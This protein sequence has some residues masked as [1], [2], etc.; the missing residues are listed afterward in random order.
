V[1]LQCK[2]KKMG[3]CRNVM[4]KW[5]QTYNR[6]F[7]T[8]RLGLAACFLAGYLLMKAIWTYFDF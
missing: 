6:V 4:E 7:T 1:A 5:V 8:K 3:L 2:E